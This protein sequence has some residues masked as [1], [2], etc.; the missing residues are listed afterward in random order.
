V[1]CLVDISVCNAGPFFILKDPATTS[2]G[3]LYTVQYQLNDHTEMLTIARNAGQ[4]GGVCSTCVGGAEG[5]TRGLR[6]EIQGVVT[7]LGN[8][9]NQSPPRISLTSARVSN[10]LTNVCAN[11]AGTYYTQCR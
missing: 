1:H 7:A 10:G 5:V 4:M 8:G 3:G 9:G 2:A 11:V 6:A